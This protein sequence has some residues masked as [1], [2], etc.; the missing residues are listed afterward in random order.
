MY[1]Y[2]RSRSALH[3]QSWQAN[4]KITES[5]YSDSGITSAL[6]GLHTF[7]DVAA[8]PVFGNMW[9]QIVLV[10]IK[11]RFPNAEIFFYR[12]SSGNEIDF[13]VRT[14]NKIFAVECKVSNS[15]SL[16][17]GNY[18]AIGDI[19]AD[20]NFVVVPSNENKWFIKENISVVSLSG[21]CEEMKQ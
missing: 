9:E 6:L 21:L 14:M 19:A 16:S 1:F 13:V 10:N 5:I 11:A 12:T 3:F 8:H 15:P 20:R 17:A 4:D 18:A 2:V 7:N